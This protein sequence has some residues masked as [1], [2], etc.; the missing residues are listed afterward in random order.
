MHVLMPW[1]NCITGT[2]KN[3]AWVNRSFLLIIL[4]FL[5]WFVFSYGSLEP[6]NFPSARAA[7]L[8]GHHVA[9]GDDFYSLFSNP[10]S[11]RSV[12]E[13]FSIAALSLSVHG[14]VF[15]LLDLFF[16]KHDDFDISGIIGKRGFAAGIDL[17]GP[18]AAGWVGRGKG[19]GLFNRTMINARVSGTR[20]RPV[21]SE[22][23]LLVGGYSHRVMDKNSHILDAGFLAKG[24]A[25]GEISLD[26]SIF[27][28]AN[29][30]DDFWSSPFRTTL[31]LG[32]D[33]GVRYAYKNGLALALV[34]HDAYSPALTTHYETFQRFRDG[35]SIS[36]SYSTLRP[37]LD[38]GISYTL[39]GIVLEKYISQM[40]FMADYFDIMDYQNTLSRNPLLNI[41]IGA[42]IRLLDA[43]D[44]RFGIGDALPAVGIGLNLTFMRL[45]FGFRGRELG[46]DPGIQPVYSLELDFIFRY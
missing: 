22:D 6:F 9:A 44:L 4:L 38:A 13:Q 45:E 2:S 15:E 39:K 10:A 27:S 24:F 7:A 23:F 46:K 11:L 3:P 5:P 42:E 8:G 1:Q 37:R 29:A 12:E 41:G 36:K 16:E 28:A 17:G 18:L 40:V 31:G 34:Y 14:P 35:N 32:V 43:L 19:I 20:I 26:A 33:L 30:F 21:A 25:R